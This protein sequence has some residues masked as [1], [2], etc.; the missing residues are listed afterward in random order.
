MDVIL[1]GTNNVCF[2]EY[3]NVVYGVIYIANARADNVTRDYDYRG[4]LYRALSA[5][6]SC[7]MFTQWL[8][9]RSENDRTNAEKKI[10]P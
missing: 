4:A 3:R 7:V 9:S 6:L 8:G 2:V 1:L 5:M 10:C